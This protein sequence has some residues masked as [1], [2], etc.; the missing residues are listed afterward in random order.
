MSHTVK[1]AQNA[2]FVSAHTWRQI[3]FKIKCQQNKPG[4]AT[5]QHGASVV[6]QYTGQRRKT[7]FAA[8]RRRSKC[9]SKSQDISN[10]RQPLAD[11]RVLQKRQRPEK[12]V[13]FMIVQVRVEYDRS[14]R[15]CIGQFLCRGQASC[16]PPA[17]AGSTSHYY[18]HYCF[19]WLLCAL[20]F[21]II[22][23]IIVSNDYHLL[24]PY[25]TD[26]MGCRKSPNDKNKNGG[27]YRY[28]LYAF[29]TT[30]FLG[31]LFWTTRWT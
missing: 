8:S 1:H 10:G 26:S 17:G 9:E 11:Q 6:R 5:V 13:R 3:L 27:L 7:A 28:A 24:A 23:C 19:R 29:F 14:N 22:V 31:S 25:N 12:L 21:P 18:V 30:L 16:P 20:M 2:L 15:V 4:Q